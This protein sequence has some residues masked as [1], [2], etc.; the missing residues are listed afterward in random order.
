MG[1][2]R[3]LRAAEDLEMAREHMWQVSLELENEEGIMSYRGIEKKIQEIHER[4]EGLRYL[5]EDAKRF[6]KRRR[7]KIRQ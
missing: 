7:R 2:S 5:L 4:L 1:T 3:R 6:E